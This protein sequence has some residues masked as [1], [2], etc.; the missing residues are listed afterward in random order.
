MRPNAM[1]LKD[2]ENF[3]SARRSAPS[4]KPKLIPES[5]QQG[6]PEAMDNVRAVVGGLTGGERPSVMSPGANEL[7]DNSELA[8]ILSGLAGGVGVGRS[9]VNAFLPN[10]RSIPR[11]LKGHSLE[12]VRAEPATLRRIEPM[13]DDYFDQGRDL[14]AA[15]DRHG[16]RLM[17]KGEATPDI[18]TI[19]NDM[20]NEGGGVLYEI[21]KPSRGWT[22]MSHDGYVAGVM[23]ENPGA[24]MTPNVFNALIN[25]HGGKLRAQAASQPLANYYRAIGLAPKKD[26]SMSFAKGGHITSPREG[27][28]LSRASEALRRAEQERQAQR[29]V[30]NQPRE[31]EWQPDHVRPGGHALEAPMISPDDLIGTGIPTKIAMALKGAAPLIG[32]LGVIKNKG[33]NWLTG[34]VED[35]LS[36]LKQRAYDARNTEEAVSKTNALNSFIDKQLTRYVKNE[37]A[38]PEDPIRALAERG[39]LHFA[40]E[41]G[42]NMSMRLGMAAR[43]RQKV[44][45]FGLAGEGVSPL[46]RQWETLS[47]SVM[48][49][50]TVGE[51]LMAE[52]PHNAETMPWLEKLHPGSQVHAIELQRGG[53]PLEWGHLTD[54]LSNALNPESGLPRH[55]LLDPKSMDRVSVPQAV[56]RVSQINAW[57][58]AQKAEADALLANN[59]ATVLHKE[60]PDKGFKW[61]ELRSPET[62]GK[63]VRHGNDWFAVDEAGRFADETPY[64]SESEAIKAARRRSNLLADALK[65]EG[66]TMGHCVGGYCD[67]VASGRTKIYSLRD[68]KGQPHVTVEVEPSSG[69]DYRN[70]PPEIRHAVNTRLGRDRTQQEFV[71]QEFPEHY[72]RLAAMPTARIKQIK[73]KQN[74]APNEEYLPFV[75]DFVKSGKWSDV[76]DLQN[77]GLIHRSR[78]NDGD[79]ETLNKLGKQ[80]PDYMTTAEYQELVESMG[81]NFAHGGTVD[82]NNLSVQQLQAFIAKYRRA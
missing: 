16:R 75:Q 39:V 46:A 34:S 45:E 29:S 67:D 77:S 50:R 57:R 82:K 52:S 24:K 65:Y 66:D 38:T 48:S 8:G 41:D 71:Q 63:A 12:A 33:G 27:G 70:L 2:L 56:E 18:A 51:Q 62:G 73:G 11:L 80:I 78:L 55:L 79:I 5:M 15:Q 74:R 35:A 4:A 37:M 6:N 13:S 23:S 7:Y 68:A 9:A 42:A 19:F 59:A 44:G 1:T 26:W 22:V 28:G 20:N 21:T 49:P 43:N 58:A 69:F 72:A 60:Y 36:G 53:D 47:D 61:V 32:G 25:E 64:R 76:G 54:E 14:L 10:A 31:P 40:P 3:I 81:N 17:A 30:F